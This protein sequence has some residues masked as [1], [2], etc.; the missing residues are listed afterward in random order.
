MCY[1]ISK[2]T[3]ERLVC[4]TKRLQKNHQVQKCSKKSSQVR[5]VYTYHVERMNEKKVR[6]ETGNKNETT[7][8]H[9]PVLVWP[10]SRRAKSSC[11]SLGLLSSIIFRLVPFRGRRGG[12]KAARG[13]ARLRGRYLDHYGSKAKSETSV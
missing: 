6:E 13:L 3:N 8:T 11:L 10:S 12:G 2:Q 4:K 7:T 1:S 5:A 9:T